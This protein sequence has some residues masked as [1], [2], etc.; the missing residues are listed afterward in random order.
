MEGY[1]D[2]KE[3]IVNGVFLRDGNFLAEKRRC[4][5][6]LCSGSVCIPGGHVEA[7]ETPEEALA[8]E[9]KEELGIDIKD[10]TLLFKGEFGKWEL[11]YFHVKRWSGKLESKVAEDIFWEA[12]AGKLTEEVE[13][14]IIS[15][16]LK[17]K[18][19]R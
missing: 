9:M 19:K 3:A 6:D 8:R 17:G 15:D 16:V 1:E 2:M 10:F 13:R 14:Q 4:D 18:A 7:G 5:D 12:D 11:Y